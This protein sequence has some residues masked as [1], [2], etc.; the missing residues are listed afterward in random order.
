MYLIISA[1]LGY[2][3]HRAHLQRYSNNVGH[4]VLSSFF[5]SS[6]KMTRKKHEAILHT[7]NP[8][9][10]RRFCLCVFVRM[11]CRLVCT[12][13]WDGHHL[14]WHAYH[15]CCRHNPWGSW[16]TSILYIHIFLPAFKNPNLPKVNISH[17]FLMTDKPFFFLQYLDKRMYQ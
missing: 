17:V 1:I 3:Q 11:L 5:I 8:S 9:C 4:F 12:M 10:Q 14:H 2:H 13:I 16:I 7:Y 6:L 15:C